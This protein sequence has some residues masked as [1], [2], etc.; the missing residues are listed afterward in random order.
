MALWLL[1]VRS[2]CDAQFSQDLGETD[3]VQRGGAGLSDANDETAQ[4]LQSGAR[5]DLLLRK[6]GDDQPEGVHADQLIGFEGDS[7][8]HRMHPLCFFG[9]ILDIGQFVARKV[10]LAWIKTGDNTL[11]H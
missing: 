3:E 7:L 9:F 5:V 6:T 2:Q 1:V 10:S 11:R 8:L 4:V